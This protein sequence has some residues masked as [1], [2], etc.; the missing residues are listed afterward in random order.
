MIESSLADQARWVVDGKF[1]TSSGV[2]AGMDVLG[3]CSTI[4]GQKTLA[5]EL[6]KKAEYVWQN[7]ADQDPF[8]VNKRAI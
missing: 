8:L 4:L 3:L 5:E 6:A 2:S 1:H 7:K